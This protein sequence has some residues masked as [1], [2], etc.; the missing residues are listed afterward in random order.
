MDIIVYGVCCIAGFLMM[1][2]DKFQSIRGGWRISE[3]ALLTMAIFGGVGVW[4]GMYVF[5]HK[6]KKPKFYIGVPVLCLLGLY[7]FEWLF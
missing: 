5:R 6:T 3:K 4:A 2:Y 1:G 7:G